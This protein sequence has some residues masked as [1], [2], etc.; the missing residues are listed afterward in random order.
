MTNYEGVY[1]DWYPFYR[2]PVLGIAIASI[3]LFVRPCVHVYVNP[4]Q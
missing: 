2:R 4:E 3:C 1:Q